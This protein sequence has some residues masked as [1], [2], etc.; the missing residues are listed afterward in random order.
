MSWQIVDVPVPGK[1]TASPAEVRTAP[2][3]PRHSV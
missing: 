3:K 2:Y 1:T